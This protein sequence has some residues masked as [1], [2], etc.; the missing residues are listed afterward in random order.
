M[1]RCKNYFNA[2]QG[3]IVLLFVGLLTALIG[4]TIHLASE[5]LNDV[6]GGYC[7]T[8]GWWN[9]KD[10]CCIEHEGNQMLLLLIHGSL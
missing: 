6:K 5:W 2:V 9:N 10:I 4:S 3:W 1:G 7:L 8:H